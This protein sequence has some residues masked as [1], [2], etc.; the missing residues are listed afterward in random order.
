MA[1][2]SV[3]PYLRVSVSPCLRVNRSSPT[4]K[5]TNP[6]AFKPAWVALVRVLPQVFNGWGDKLVIRRS[7]DHPYRTWIAGRK[8]Y[9]SVHSILLL[10]VPLLELLDPAGRVYQLLLACVERM[11]VGT[12]IYGLAVNG[13]AGLV[14]CAAGTGKYG[15]FVF[16]V[17]FFFHRYYSL[18]LLYA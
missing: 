10:L 3:S 17:Q 6:L 16:R 8:P 2:L 1:F 5:H 14:G 18:S 11:A 4:H 13:G 12:D 15:S 9:L 7:G